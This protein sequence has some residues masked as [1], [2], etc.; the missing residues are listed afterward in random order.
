MCKEHHCKEPIATET[1]GKEKVL[2]RIT[3]HPCCFLK[4]FHK[5]WFTHGF[6][7]CFCASCLCCYWLFTMLFIAWVLRSRFSCYMWCSNFQNWF[8]F[9]FFRFYFFYLISFQSPLLFFKAQNILGWKS[10]K[11]GC[12]H[13]EVSKIY[14]CNRDRLGSI[15]FFFFTTILGAYL[16][17]TMSHISFRLV[18]R[19][20]Y[21]AL[22]P[23]CIFQ[24]Q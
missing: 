24:L 4:V 1:G 23:P 8:Y 11:T 18:E 17:I 15:F 16:Q 22:C 6:L 12:C 7:W 13:L 2:L 21:D 10:G 19:S 20:G 3:S 9:Y 5:Q 14:P